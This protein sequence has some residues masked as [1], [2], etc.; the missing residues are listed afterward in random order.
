M[1]GTFSKLKRF[2]SRTSCILVLSVR[3]YSPLFYLTM[4]SY[5][6]L[7]GPLIIPFLGLV[8]ADSPVILMLGPS[9]FCTGICYKFSFEA[10]IIYL[11]SYSDA[12]VVQVFLIFIELMI[13]L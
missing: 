12:G 13:I 1:S 8:A 9:I 4:V 2:C 5:C 11:S 3:N 7:G 6:Y 10:I